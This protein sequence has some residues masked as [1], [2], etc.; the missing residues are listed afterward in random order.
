MPHIGI[1]VNT[2]I[3]G[4][5]L[6]GESSKGFPV[7]VICTAYKYLLCRNKGKALALPKVKGSL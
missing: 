1:L 7:L 2:G 3:S 5:I 4:K 6:F